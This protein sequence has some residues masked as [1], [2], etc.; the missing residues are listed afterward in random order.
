MPC[1]VRRRR[2]NA[3]TKTR[4]PW[5]SEEV[6]CLTG[7]WPDEHITQMF[8]FVKCEE[9]MKERH[10]ECSVSVVQRQ[11][12]IKDHLVHIGKRVWVFFLL[13]LPGST[14][15]EYFVPVAGSVVFSLQKK[16]KTPQDSN[17]IAPRP[18]LLAELGLV[19]MFHIWGPMLRSRMSKRTEPKWKHPLVSENI[20][21][22]S[23][24]SLKCDWLLYTNHTCVLV[25][26]L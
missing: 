25:V 22:G 21:S 6:K 2:D 5:F 12:Y 7:I 13:L 19:V 3:S 8:M 11:Q 26:L 16:T 10:C 14:Y 24:S 18:H 17:G 4:L 9:W 23:E 1:I 20:I 15:Q